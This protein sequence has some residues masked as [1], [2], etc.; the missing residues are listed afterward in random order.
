MSQPIA[1][2]AGRR[3][4][5]RDVALAAGVSIGTVSRAMTN[6]ARILPETRARVL[7]TV[8]RMGYVPD[9]AAQSMRSNQTKVIGCAV[10]LASHPVFTAL[11]SAA[12][13]VLREAGYAM[14]LGNT[15]D[16]TAREIELMTFFRQRNVDGI[17]TTL[18]REDDPE[19]IERLRAMQVPVVLIDRF[20]AEGCDSVQTDQAEGCRAAT[21]Y[22]LSL[23]HRRIALVTSALQ[24]LPGRERR[25]SFLGAY[26]ES[27]IDASAA[28][29]RTM[30]SP[31]DFGISESL[32]LL[33]GPNP[34]TAVIVGVQELIGLLRAVRAR[35]MTIPN[36]LSVITL[37]DSDLAE[38][39]HPAITTVRWDGHEVGRIAAKLLLQRMGAAPQAWK[40][41]VIPTEFVIRA[42]C[43]P[44][45]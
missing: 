23:G 39:I 38:M 13:H 28:M 42:S 22:L 35:G 8:A 5:I 31:S 29:V 44:P 36:D 4:T 18:A 3:V 45:R 34:P 26:A 1:G 30:D 9:G 16:R 41:V 7:A 17:I 27:G 2:L 19:A 11:L 37:G 12:E 40:R 24:N 6:H 14:V 32:E 25:T 21:S 15:A 20:V 43:A 33:G 10:P